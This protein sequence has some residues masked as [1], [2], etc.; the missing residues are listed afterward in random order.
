MFACDCCHMC[1][2]GKIKW[3][4][5]TSVQ[6]PNLSLQ[7]QASLSVIQHT[8]CPYFALRSTHNSAKTHSGLSL[9]QENLTRVHTQRLLYQ[10]CPPSLLEQWTPIP[11]L[12]HATFDYSVRKAFVVSE[13]RSCSHGNVLGMRWLLLDTSRENRLSTTSPLQQ[14]KGSRGNNY[15]CVSCVENFPPACP[16]L[17]HSYHDISLSLVWMSAGPSVTH[18]RLTADLCQSRCPLVLALLSPCCCCCCCCHQQKLIVLLE[19]K[20]P[21]NLSCSLLSAQRLKR[22]V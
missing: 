19:G 21:W 6:K 15:S 11:L 3:C 22:F 17:S 8:L 9:P 7:I 4:Y 2:K 10:Y 18:R 13:G 14:S 5:L 20:T 16:A 1:H 12:P